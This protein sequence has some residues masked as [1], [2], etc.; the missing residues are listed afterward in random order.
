MVNGL[1][2]MFGEVENK[3]GFVFPTEKMLATWKHEADF[4]FHFSKHLL[5]SSSSMKPSPG[6]K[7]TD[8]RRTSSDARPTSS[9]SP[10]DENA[11]PNLTTSSPAQGR[12]R[13]ADD[14]EYWYY[15]SQGWRKFSRTS[16]GRQITN[17]DEIFHRVIN[18]LFNSLYFTEVAISTL[19][20]SKPNHFKD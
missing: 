17:Q 20:L 4:V 16:R 9:S 2:E 5:L 13:K 19:W 14:D 18:D 1:E 12:K 3:V 7:S 6:K 8:S 10:Q 15:P 11:S